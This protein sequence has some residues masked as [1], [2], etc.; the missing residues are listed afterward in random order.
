[1]E[2]NH[3]LSESLNLSAEPFG[4]MEPG[5]GF[6]GKTR[7]LTSDVDL[8]AMYQLHK[9]RREILLWCYSDLDSSQLQQT[10][11]KAHN[12]RRL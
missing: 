3:K 6:K 4:Y 8:D 5:H 12:S 1:M 7:C 9:S 11:K 10:Q 2:L